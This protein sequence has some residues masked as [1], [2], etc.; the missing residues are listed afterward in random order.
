[1]FPLVHLVMFRL[2]HLVMFRLVRLVMFR[3]VRLVMFRLVRLVM[4]RLR[5]HHR[6]MTMET[7]VTEMMKMVVMNQIQ[8]KVDLLAATK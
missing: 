2:V 4:F 6:P 7:T 1:M 8:A 5:P 3:L